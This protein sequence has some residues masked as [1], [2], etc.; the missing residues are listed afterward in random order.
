MELPRLRRG[1]AR[2]SGGRASVSGATG[3]ASSMPDQQYTRRQRRSRPVRRDDAPP[4]TTRT[5]GHARPQW[6]WRTFPV[7]AAF[8][9]GIVVMGL[10]ASSAFALA[11]FFIGLFC[12]MLSIAHAVRLQIVASRRRR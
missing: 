5:A 7:F 6:Q 1:P 9:L 2:G 3:N 12:L 11:V 4:A 10:F 8:A